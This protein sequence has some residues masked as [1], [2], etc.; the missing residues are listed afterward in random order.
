M[1]E[2]LYWVFS[3]AYRRVLSDDEWAVR[4]RLSQALVQ[5]AISFSSVSCLD[6]SPIANGV[7]VVIEVKG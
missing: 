2:P 7:G 4:I 1:D 3:H 5:L 6:I